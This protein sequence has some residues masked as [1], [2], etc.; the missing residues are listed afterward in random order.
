MEEE[1]ANTTVLSNSDDEN[2]DDDTDSSPPAIFY[3]RQRFGQR[4]ISID[5]PSKH[6]LLSA[7]KALSRT[8]RF[9]VS[10][11]NWKLR[12]NNSS[13]IASAASSEDQRSSRN[14]GTSSDDRQQSNP[15]NDTLSSPITRSVEQHQTKEEQ[16]DEHDQ[17]Q[18]SRRQQPTRTKVVRDFFILRGLKNLTKDENR[19]RSGPPK[20]NVTKT[21]NLKPFIIS[22]ARE[23]ALIN[24]VRDISLSADNDYVGIADSF[25]IRASILARNGD[26]GRAIA[27]L[28]NYLQWRRS[29]RYHERLKSGLNPAIRELLATGTFTVAGN[30][31]LNEQPVLTIRYEYYEPSRYETVD[32][33]MT[34]AVLVEYLMREFPKSLTHGMVVMEEMSRASVSNLDIRLA[35]FLS[36]A[37]SS[38]IPLRIAAMFFVNPKKGVRTALRFMSPFLAR[39]FKTRVYVMHDNSVERFASFFAHDQT[40]TFMNMHGTMEWTHKNQQRL[41]AIVS[42]KC[43]TWPKASTFR[44]SQ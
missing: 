6:G 21:D 16:D 32:A 2:E 11:F 35:H 36:R 18:Q 40:P 41:A 17:N 44:D 31:A 4:D 9:N 24:K 13:G 23:T 5:R 27:L 8:D 29:V 37:F 1:E 20:A 19:Q 39:K 30:K 22:R 33:T 15:T 14:D 42:E 26:V 3:R 25:W 28:T 7:S 12:L 38:I 43:T 34:F 10:E